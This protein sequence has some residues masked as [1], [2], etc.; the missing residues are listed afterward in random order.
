LSKPNIEKLRKEEVKPENS[1][2]KRTFK[3]GKGGDNT[4]F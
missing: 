1:K 2:P 3:Y 4:A